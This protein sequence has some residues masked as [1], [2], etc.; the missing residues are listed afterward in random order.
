M[1]RIKHWPVL[2]L[3]FLAS[4]CLHG[5]R[6][7]P[8]DLKQRVTPNL[9][10]H[11]V[12]RDPAASVGK[13]VLLGGVIL[14]T[15]VYKERTVLEVIQKPLGFRDRPLETDESGGRFLVER[16]GQFLDPGIYKAGREVTLIGEIVKEE[17]KPLD[18][19]EYRYPYVTA[20]HLY[21]WP[22]RPEP[23]VFYPYCRTAFG[24]D[25]Y[26]P[27]YPHFYRSRFGPR[28]YNLICPFFHSHVSSRS[29]LRV[30]KK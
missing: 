29:F 15:T 2:M 18:E 13:T 14:K 23:A 7:I 3:A 20:S 9:A 11:E 5:V 16:T 25:C 19:M 1:I 4:G 21:L 22:E 30:H 27:F 28:P 24:C 12:I 8:E 10:F 26:D 6:A 17:R